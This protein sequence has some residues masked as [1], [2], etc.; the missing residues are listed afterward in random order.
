MTNKFEP[1]S[2]RPAAFE[3]AGNVA[4]AELVNTPVE[5]S[6]SLIVAA[7]ATNSLL[8]DTAMPKRALGAVTTPPVPHPRTAAPVEALNARS[9]QSYALVTNRVLPSPDNAMAR[10]LRDDPPPTKTGEKYGDP[11]MVLYAAM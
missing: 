11:S 8:P 2:A 1:D 3:P 5:A 9:D 7:F 6:Y 10:G 4:N